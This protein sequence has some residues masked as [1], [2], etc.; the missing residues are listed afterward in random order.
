M[1]GHAHVMLARRGTG[2][3]HRRPQQA[4][5]RQNRP[6]PCTRRQEASS[7]ESRVLRCRRG[8]ALGRRPAF[9]LSLKIGHQ[10]PLRRLSSGW[11]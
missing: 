5:D 4:G 8:S 6:D 7:R 3:R 1:V 2:I 10:S 9:A 11:Q